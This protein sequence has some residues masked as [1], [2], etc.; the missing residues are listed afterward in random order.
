MRELRKENLVTQ[1]NNLV[2]ARYTLTKNE[3]L[4]L[5]AMIS[6]IDPN[7]KDFLTYKTS[8]NRFAE[9]LGVNN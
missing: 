4:I 8:I 3:Q 2:E 6:F 5:C 7:D 1:A 9:L